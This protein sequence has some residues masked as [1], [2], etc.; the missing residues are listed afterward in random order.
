MPD[1]A[2]YRRRCQYDELVAWLRVQR[3]RTV[4]VTFREVEALLH[5]PLPGPAYSGR[6]WWM[7]PGRPRRTG[8]GAPPAGRCAPWIDGSAS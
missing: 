2:P 4:T 3:G 5:R 7:P 8:T 1:P 6:A